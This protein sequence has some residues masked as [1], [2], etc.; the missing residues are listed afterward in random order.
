MTY[1]PRQ[2][3]P[4]SGRTLSNP[5]PE[6]LQRYRDNA[7][8]AVAAP[9]K[10]ITT[11]GTPVPGLFPIQA[12]GVSTA[13][14]RRRGRRAA[15]RARPRAGG[16]RALSARAPTRGAGGAT[17]TPSSC[18]TA[19][20]LDAT[21]AA[22]R[23]RAL[24]LV[25]ASLSAGRL[26]AARDVMRLN[27][28]IAEIT[29][30][31]DEYGEWLYWLSVLGTPVRPPSRGAGRSTAT[32][33]SSTAWCSA[34]RSCSRRCSWARSPWSRCPARTPARACSRRRS[35]RAWLCCT[36]STPA[37]AR[38]RSSRAESARRGAHRG[39]PRQRRAQA[40]RASAGA[41]SRPASR[42]CCGACSTPTSGG[43]APAT[44]A[45]G[46]EEVARHLDET[47]FAWIG[48]CRGRQRLLLPHPQPGHPDRVRSPARRRASTTTSRRA[49]TSTPSC[50]RPTATT[51]A[52]T[53][54]ASTTRSS[55]IN[56]G[57]NSM[58]VDNDSRPPITP[59][60]G[61]SAGSVDLRLTSAD[62]TKFMAYA[63]RAAKPTG[64]GM[65]VIPDVRGLHQYYKDLADRFAEVGVDAV[66]IDFFAPHGALRRPQ[67]Q[68]RIHVARGADEAGNV[69]GRHRRRRGLSARQGGR[70]GALALLGGLLLRRRAVLSAGGQRPRL[71]RRHRLL[72]LAAGPQALA[73]SAQADRRGRPLQ[74]A[75][76]LALRRRRR[77]D[78]AGRRR[79]VRQRL[80][81]GLA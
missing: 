13:A 72:R 37:S 4:V 46:C 28:V 33:S 3:P 19:S 43:S 45:C 25:E 56:P 34:T 6:G 63:V 22:Q 42:A 41:S 44:P 49:T 36:R 7:E 2:R 47:R 18:A 50:A 67:R 35:S 53:C 74:V 20:A 70:A 64:A 32:T 59:I 57:G 51:T 79:R 12:T 71:R 78:P 17:S 1:R 62:G 8:A 10:G 14:H 23:E 75:G 80:Q 81:E 69:A 26:P 68:V 65:L 5:L 58:C 40:T 66:A 73:G 24:A 31:P 27:Q 30:R 48:G 21:D 60:A 9:F 38:G 29:G 52:R 61:G 39:V 55:T 11:D 77:G 16:A 76:A 54:C 15:G